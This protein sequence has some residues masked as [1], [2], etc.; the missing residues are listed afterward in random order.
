MAGLVPAIAASLLMPVRKKNVYA[1]TRPGVTTLG[2][3]YFF[4][5]ILPSVPACNRL[6]FSRC[7]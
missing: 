4:C 2:R 7:L 1:G 6:M 5:P 3:S